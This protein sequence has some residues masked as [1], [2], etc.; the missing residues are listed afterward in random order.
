MEVQTVQE[1]VKYWRGFRGRSRKTLAAFPANAGPWRPAEG[2]FR[3]ADLA[4]HLG[5]AERDFFV[6]RVCGAPA[7]V[8]IGSEA[9]LGRGGDPDLHSA[10]AE[11]DALHEESCA[12]LSDLEVREGP[13]ALER[14]VTT[15]VGADIT[16]W[17][18]LRAM[19][20]HEAH[21]RGQLALYLRM[22]G[23]DP[24]PIFG[25]KAE[26]VGEALRQEQAG[27][28]GKDQH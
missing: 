5:R 22:L 21:H 28:R 15:P 8:A 24:P 1:F 9:A 20:E 12:M 13:R 23:V 19:C 10:L 16:A 25:H 2:A 3:V 26:A 6:A 7:R 14:R 17:K 11:L 27:S 4:R 18:L